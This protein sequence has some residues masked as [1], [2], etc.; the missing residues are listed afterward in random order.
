MGEFGNVEC[1]LTKLN[2]VLSFFPVTHV[3]SKQ[4]ILF[5]EPADTGSSYPDWYTDELHAL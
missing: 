1:G 2:I 5:Q 3:N 4:V